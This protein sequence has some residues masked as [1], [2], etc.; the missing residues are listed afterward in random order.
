MHNTNENSEYNNV[1]LLTMNKLTFHNMKEVEI[2]HSEKQENTKK[3]VQS[4]AF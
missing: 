2:T 3:P 1:H 4:S